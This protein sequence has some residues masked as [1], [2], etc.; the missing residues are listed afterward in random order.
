MWTQQRITLSP[1]SRGYHLITDEVLAQL[2]RVENISVGMLHLFIQHTSASLTVNENADPS[3]RQDMETHI[4]KMVPDNMAYYLHN[5]EGA[6]DMPAHI[7]ASLI[8]SDVTIPISNG[9]LALGM[10][11]GIVLGEHR[12]RAGSRLLIATLSGQ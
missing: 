10:W 8:G 7:K 12:N 9:T 5:Y 2:N 6:D 1:K 3:V 11:Q 4:N